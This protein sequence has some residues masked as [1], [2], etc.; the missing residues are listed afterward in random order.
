MRKFIY[1]F[2]ALFSN[3]FRY[4]YKTR[5][6]V[7]A[8]HNIPDAKLFAKQ[9]KHLKSKY[10]IIGVPELLDYFNNNDKNLPEFPLLITFDDGDRSVLEYGLPELKKHNIPACIFIITGLINT[11]E[12]FWNKKVFNNEIKKG[13]SYTESRKRVN[14]LKLVSNKERLE[15][16]QEYLPGYQ[17]QLSTEELKVFENTKIFI[18]NHSHTHPMFDQC[19]ENEIVAEL[20]NSKNFFEIAHVGNY[21]VFAYP[22]GNWDSLSEYLL[23]TN[24]INFAFLFDHKINSKKMN[25]MRISRIRTN[26]DMPLSELKVKASGLHSL[27][28]NLR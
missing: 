23:K 14:D 16:I 27:I 25:P 20:K 7:L 5:L 9:L 10:T 26:A 17:P 3:F 18:G 19:T 22:N 15:L 11:N 8:Y 6:R 28:S 24:S 4:Y 1:Y 21:E 12:T 2:F 13:N